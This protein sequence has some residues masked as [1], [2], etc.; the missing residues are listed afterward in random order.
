MAST[1]SEE[2]RLAALSYHRNPRPGKL[3]IQAT[4]PL[5]CGRG[6]DPALGQAGCGIGIEDLLADIVERVPVA[7]RAHAARQVGLGF[8][9]LA[10]L[11]DVFGGLFGRHSLIPGPFGLGRQRQDFGGGVELGRLDG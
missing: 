9:A 10:H 2:L 11:G 6:H 8:G 7:D 5:A 3:E 1:L 4:K